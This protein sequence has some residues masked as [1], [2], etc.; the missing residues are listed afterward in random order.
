[1]VQALAV[2]SRFRQYETAPQVARDIHQLVKNLTGKPDPYH[3][4]KLDHIRRALKL[5]PAIREQIRQS[6]DPL[7]YALKASAVGNMIDAAIYMDIQIETIIDEQLG[8]DFAK[9][10]LEQFRAHLS[11]AKT[12]L[13]I[14]DNAGE[15]VFDKLLIEQ[16][17]G[18]SVYYA[19]K[20]KP[21][22]ND[23]TY[24]D[25]VLSGLND[26][27]IQIIE[28]GCDS[29]GTLLQETTKEF[30]DLFNVAD[31]VISKGQGN[32]EGLSDCKR[33]VFYL[34]KAKCAMVAR[35]F[36]VRQGEDVFHL[37]I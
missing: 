20:S 5:C 22:I 35:Y 31:I 37:A 29:P 14:G 30:H 32:F 11:T 23:A 26:K 27:G 36:G 8:Q 7:K 18:Y 10:D 12:I 13:I 24:A 1:M 6:D 33:P 21:I 25:A 34:L 28:S 4:L 2:L 17:A 3:D 9:C 16:L 19:V 15:S